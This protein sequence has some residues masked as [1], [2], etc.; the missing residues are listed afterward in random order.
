MNNNQSAYRQ[1]VKATSIFGGVQVFSIIISIVRSKFIAVLLGPLGMGIAGLLTSTTALIASITNFGLA[2]SAVRNIAEANGTGDSGR[3]AKVV[4][5]F[6]KLVWATGLIGSL[7]TLILAPWLS[8]MTF[9][10]RDYTLAF[11]F[12]SVTLLLG[13]I[14]SGQL[15]LLQ[16]MRQ[17]HLLAKASLLGSL[18]GLIVSVPIYYLYGIDGIVPAII[19]SSCISMLLSFYFSS[20]IKIQKMAVSPKDVLSEGRG[21]LVMGFLIGLTGF[22]D[23]IIAYATNIFISNYGNVK[24]V[25]MYNAGFSLVNTYVGMIFAAML[26]DYYPRL[27]SVAKNNQ[28]AKEMMNQ[29]AEIAILILA[30]II[31]CFFVFINLVILILYSREFLVADE[32]IYWAAIGIFIKAVNWSIGI[33][34]L[35]KGESKLYF[36]T[37]VLAAFIVLGTN[38][39][40]Y[41]LFG[42]KGLGIAFLTSYVLLT[43]IGYWIVKVKY[44]FSFSL[45]F[46]KIFAIQFLLGIICFVS[47][48]VFK[49][50]YTYLIGIPLILISTIFSYKE[51]DKRIGILSVIQRV[52]SRFNKE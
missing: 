52:K 40:G 7:S 27:S 2:T 43:I 14:S 24:D 44:S 35:A 16:G 47:I 3:I 30:P 34:L 19:I 38:I 9:G 33:L 20:K 48:Q 11:V 46:L 45:E 50:P 31:M 25:G 5:V 22:I 17:I 51:L 15:V 49:S 12:L 41:Y 42:L 13:Q 21:M 39:S 36:V 29:Q 1:I 26:T 32:M 6:K 4:I 23:Q 8:E 37:Y 18:I 10:N 28:L